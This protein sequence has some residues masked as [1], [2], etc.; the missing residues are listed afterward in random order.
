MNRLILFLMSLTGFA[1][2]CMFVYSVWTERQKFFVMYPDTSLD[3][4]ADWAFM[5]CGVM[6]ALMC[7]NFMWEALTDK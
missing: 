4:S 2:S 5:A 6:L 3:R 7:V 1:A